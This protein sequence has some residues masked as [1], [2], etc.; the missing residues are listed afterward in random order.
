MD[1]P[2]R[3]QLRQADVALRKRKQD[4]GSAM[5]HSA[6]LAQDDPARR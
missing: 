3:L 6:A 4:D 1:S 2:T 5:S